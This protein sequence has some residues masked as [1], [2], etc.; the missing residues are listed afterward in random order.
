MLDRDTN[1]EN[2]VHLI[3]D[4]IA[5]FTDR[6]ANG[7]EVWIRQLFRDIRGS[8]WDEI[9]TIYIETMAVKLRRLVRS[10]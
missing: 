4:K 9:L 5:S 8:K 3:V 7:D 6:I 1:V 10:Y 2:I